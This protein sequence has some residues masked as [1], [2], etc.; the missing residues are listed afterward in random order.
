MGGASYPTGSR[1]SGRVDIYS[2]SS[3][4]GPHRKDW[5]RKPIVVEDGGDCYFRIEYDSQTHTFSHLEING[6]A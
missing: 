4:R 3:Q 2:V 1:F 6:E 5:T